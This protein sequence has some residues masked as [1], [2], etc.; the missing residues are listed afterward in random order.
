M[1]VYLKHIIWKCD[2]GVLYQ[3]LWNLQ[4]E[5]QHYTFFLQLRHGR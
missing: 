2:V 3:G 5:L 4:L 1:V